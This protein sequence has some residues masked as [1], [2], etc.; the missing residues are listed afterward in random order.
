M[1]HYA[2][3]AFTLVFGCTMTLAVGAQSNRE[4]SNS[5]MTARPAALPLS[6]VSVATSKVETVASETVISVALSQSLSSKTAKRNA[7][8]DAVTTAPLM[9]NGYIL[10]PVGTHMTGRVV[11]SR[12]AGY[13]SLPPVLAIELTGAR[14]SAASPRGKAVIVPLLTRPS[15]GSSQNGRLTQSGKFRDIQ[16]KLHRV[17]E[18]Y[19]DGPQTI[20]VAIEEGQQ[21]SGPTDI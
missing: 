13:H 20:A 1:K 19:T 12:R 9:S 15:L 16:L 4:V 10:I 17:V 8:F 5:P 2:T 7:T 6:R 21:I 3:F 14:M 11:L 18:F